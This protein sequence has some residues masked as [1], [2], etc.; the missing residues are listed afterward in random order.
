VIPGGHIKAC[1]L[2]RLR[3]DLIL[4][5]QARLP[6]HLFGVSFGMSALRAFL[7]GAAGWLPHSEPAEEVCQ[8]VPALRQRQARWLTTTG[9]LHVLAVSAIPRYISWI[10]RRSVAMG[11]RGP[12]T[13]TGQ[14]NDGLLVNIS[15]QAQL[16]QR[17][18]HDHIP[19]W[20]KVNG[21]LKGPIPSRAED[22]RNR[23]L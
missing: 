21:W 22:A 13:R 14:R 3:A 20:Y 17:P 9:R 1:W 16:A 11:R 10:S 8:R 18:S 12:R 2:S 5:L 19:V 6:I 4:L 23:A 7:L 15:G